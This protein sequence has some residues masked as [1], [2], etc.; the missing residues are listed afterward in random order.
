MYSDDAFA[1]MLLTIALSADRAEY[2]RP[3]NT[4]EYCR[5]LA[6]VKAS[7]AGR[8]GALLR[9][10]ISALMMLLGVSL[11]PLYAFAPRRAA[12]LCAGRLY[13]ERRARHHLL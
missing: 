1:T 7:A 8:L 4:A 6:R 11:P 3:L 5:V 13:A 10:D 2:A 9:A 12:Y